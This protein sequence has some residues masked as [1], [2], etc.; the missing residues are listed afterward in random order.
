MINPKTNRIPFMI[1]DDELSKVDDWRFANRIGS[2]AA[3]IRLLCAK[4]L[5]QEKADYQR[6]ETGFRNIVS[7]I[8]LTRSDFEIPEIVERV[9]RLAEVHKDG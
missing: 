8:G 3:A 5:E 6:W 2:R 7:A 9:R 1:S 4:Q